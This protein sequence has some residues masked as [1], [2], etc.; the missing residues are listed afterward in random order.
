MRLCEMQEIIK[1]RGGGLSVLFITIQLLRQ[2]EDLLY[3]LGRNPI[4]K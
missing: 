3:H 1:L 2:P 4:C